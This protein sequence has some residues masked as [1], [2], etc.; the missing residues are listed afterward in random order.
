[1]KLN[2]VPVKSMLF[3]QTGDCFEGNFSIRVMD[4]QGKEVLNKK[5]IE[6][7]NAGLLINKLPSGIYFAVLE[8]EQGRV[9]R[10]FAK[11]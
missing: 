11:E 3:V 5:M 8:N 4:I 1:M 7:S 9:V 6:K 10:K 2:P